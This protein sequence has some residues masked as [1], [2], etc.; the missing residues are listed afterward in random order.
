MQ[1][2]PIGHASQ[3]IPINTRHLS[4]MLSQSS[5]QR[6]PKG[7]QEL[8]LQRSQL[9]QH[10]EFWRVSVSEMTVITTVWSEFLWGLRKSC[11]GSEGRR[12]RSTNGGRQHNKNGCISTNKVSFSSKIVVVSLHDRNHDGVVRIF[13]DHS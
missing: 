4:T 13:V 7:R 10:G 3:L 5:Q 11:T 2:Q 12:E 1:L 6:Q 8:I 9:R